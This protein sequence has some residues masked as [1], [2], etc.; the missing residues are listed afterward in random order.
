MRKLTCTI[1]GTAVLAAFVAAAASAAPSL[2]PEDA[3]NAA[4][5]G[6]PGVAAAQARIGA[7]QAGAA[8]LRRGAHEVTLGG[9]VVR[10]DVRGEGRFN[11]F[12][13]TL[14]RAFRLPG[15]AALDRKAGELGVEVAENRMDDMRHQAA[16]MLA[17]QW[18]DWLEASEL[19]RTDLATAALLE[20][21]LQ[22]IS[23]RAELRDAAVLEVEQAKAALD[24]ARAQ[25][26]SSLAD[27]EQARV[28]LA[29]TFP[30]LPLPVEAPRLGTPDALP[31]ADMLRMR[32]LVLA[33]SH[34][35]MAA[36]REAARLGT[37]AE[38]ARRDR[39][40]DPTFGLRAFSERGGVERGGGVTLSIPLGG[41]YRKAA[42]EQAEAEAGAG[43]MDL[44]VVRREIEATANA[45]LANARNRVRAWQGLAAAAQ[46]SLAAAE[47]MARGHALGAIDLT[48]A[49]AARR[50]ARDAERQEIAARSSAIRAL[51]KLQIDSHEVWMT[52]HH[53]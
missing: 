28:M 22:A 35:I 16:L 37:V 44:A 49:L 29:A 5:D 8:M 38:R 17:Q 30:D 7:A 23:R 18:F 32:D 13:G 9:S 24:Q 43:L 31:E 2:P 40:A 15:K 20:Q 12:D 34:E 33:R 51:M 47:R 36:D 52:E 19:H 14:S 42:A 1:R 3:V 26:A 48:D 53:D 10:R 41:G 50:L 25:S 45:D 46:S 21:S 27:L 39:I 6:Y 4:L 11:E